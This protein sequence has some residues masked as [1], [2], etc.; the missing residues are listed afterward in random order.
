MS[1]RSLLQRRVGAA[2]RL[3]AIQTA[4]FLAA[5]FPLAA[6]YGLEG[7]AFATLTGQVV[8]FT[9]YGLLIQLSRLGGGLLAWIRDWAP[10]AFAGMATG[11][12][13]AWLIPPAQSRAIAVLVVVATLGI[14]VAASVL[15]SSTIRHEAAQ[16][17][18]RVRRAMSS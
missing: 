3:T 5:L 1:S 18:K 4:I 16:V 12:L 13:S 7:A 2:L 17:G 9:A 15:L 14:A 8:L 11:A 6:A 10:A